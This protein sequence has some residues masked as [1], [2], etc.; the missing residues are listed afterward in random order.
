MSSDDSKRQGS[1][2][3]VIPGIGMHV[4]FRCDTCR[5]NRPTL[6]RKRTRTGWMCVGCVRAKDAQKVAA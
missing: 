1:T 3:W 4:Q 6:G 5:V 2:R